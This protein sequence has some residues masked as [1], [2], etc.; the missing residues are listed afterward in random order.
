[1]KRLSLIGWPL[2]WLLLFEVALAV[3][4]YAAALSITEEW[5]TST[6]L[7]GTYNRPNLRADA[8]AEIRGA[9]YIAGMIVFAIGA[10]AS[11]LWL[12]LAAWYP[13]RGPGRAVWLCIGW[14]ILLAAAEAAAMAVIY[15]KMSESGLVSSEGMAWA[16]GLGTALLVVTY[17]V[18]GTLW[19][20]P[21]RAAPAVPGARFFPPVLR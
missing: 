19:P 3:I 4:L 9:I 2:F 16:F 21:L 12:L 11:L 15:L 1:M 17:W 8:T 20:T 18:V 7:E 5:L 10:G 14:A 6:F 13:I